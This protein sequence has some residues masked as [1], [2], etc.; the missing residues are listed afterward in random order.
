MIGDVGEVST[1][2]SELNPSIVDA[3]W[4]SPSEELV[5]T[6]SL[7]STIRTYAILMIQLR[8]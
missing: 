5:D 2:K 6:R 1:E 7:S 4:L 8:R 3:G